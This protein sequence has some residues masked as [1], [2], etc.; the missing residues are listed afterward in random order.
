MGKEKLGSIYARCGG[1]DT[2]FDLD[3]LWWL[4]ETER[5]LESFLDM[6]FTLRY[7]AGSRLVPCSYWT[8]VGQWQ[9]FLEW[10]RLFEVA[11]QEMQQCS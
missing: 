9:R 5:C 10:K 3:C 8:L 11:R 1:C 6:G 7:L 4:L 2:F